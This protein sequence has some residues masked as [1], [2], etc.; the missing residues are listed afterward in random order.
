M[1]LK[2]SRLLALGLCIAFLCGRS[3]PGALA[4]DQHDDNLST[5][6]SFPSED[7]SSGKVV[8]L[9]STSGPASLI[10]ILVDGR[11]LA[12][13]PNTGAEAWTWDTGSP[14][15]SSAGLTAGG[16]DGAHDGADGSFHATRTLVPGVDGALYAYH[17]QND[18]GDLQLGLQ[19]QPQTIPELV[20]A[21]PSMM[22]DGS[23][24][25]GSRT[26]SVYLLDPDSGTL[27]SGFFDVGASPADLPGLIGL[28]PEEVA[29]SQEPYAGGKARPLAIGR[30]VYRLGVSDPATGEERWN[31]SFARVHPLTPQARRAALD[32]RN[33]PS[34]L[35]DEVTT[36]DPGLLGISVEGH[37]LLKRRDPSTGRVIW[38]RRLSAAPVGVYTSDGAAV[39]LHHGPLRTHSQVV[40][41]QDAIF[42]SL[43]EG[44]L[45]ALPTTHIPGMGQ[46][47]SDFVAGSPEGW[48]GSLAEGSGVS[49]DP[50]ACPLG[51][52]PVEPA[53][54]LPPSQQMFLPPGG[55]PVASQGPFVVLEQGWLHGLT[56]RAQRI[57]QEKRWLSMLAALFVGALLYSAGQSLM[58]FRKP[59]V[60]TAV[61]R[62]ANGALHMEVNF[63]GTNQ[64][65]NDLKRSSRTALEARAGDG[66]TI[67]DY[68][69]SGVGNSP[70]ESSSS[71]SSSGKG[72]GRQKKKGARHPRYSNK[73]NGL[74]QQLASQASTA[75]D[76]DK[77]EDEESP[78]FPDEQNGDVLNP[79]PPIQERDHG[80]RADAGRQGD[81]DSGDPGLWQLGH[82][83]VRGHAGRAAG[84]CEEAAAP[85]L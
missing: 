1:R 24:V 33:M 38:S 64:Q 66:P 76:P 17:H 60:D 84:R 78:R 65:L 67:R 2:K 3:I 59:H 41:G 54:A 5:E 73:R 20:D 18:D 52:H 30:H 50:W 43:V 32:W 46:R 75:S 82:S 35:E 39:P 22:A 31:I 23:V 29:G 21:S 28:G 6:A 68:T 27:V 10:V 85:V 74:L 71:A 79:R 45:V 4:R 9:L 26:T 47:P 49:G 11:L 8:P 42:V 61:D 56:V 19:K 7:I 34:V 12:L 25:L 80:G 36:A 58:Y 37:L 14:L 53:L 51:Y 62:D 16:A 48:R 63:T 57:F 77:E 81:L 13:D 55:E 83:G 15:V 44:S 69:G 72:S 40:E 70:D